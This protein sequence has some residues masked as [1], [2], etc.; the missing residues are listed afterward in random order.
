[1]LP[2]SIYTTVLSRLYGFVRTGCFLSGLFSHRLGAPK[3]HGSY[4]RC[5]REAFAKDLL[6]TLYNHENPC[7]GASLCVAQKQCFVPGEPPGSSEEQDLCLEDRA[8]HG[9]TCR[10]WDAIRSYF[11]KGQYLLRHRTDKQDSLLL[12]SAPLVTEF[13]LGDDF[14]WDW[15]MWKPGVRHLGSC[16]AL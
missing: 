13:A 3:R 11:W 9:R 7:L 15:G 4:Y 14:G 12:F 2:C 5:P 8:G 10:E 1:M 6:K 16:L